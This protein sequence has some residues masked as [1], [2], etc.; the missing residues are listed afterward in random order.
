MR[1]AV[2]AT[3][4]LKPPLGVTEIVDV[5]PVIA[6]GVTVTAVPLTAKLGPTTVVPVTAFVPE[7]LL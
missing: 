3:L 7:A 6:P 4:P 2:S 1:L 5:L